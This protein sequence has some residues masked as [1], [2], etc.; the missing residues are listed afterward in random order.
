[1]SKFIVI[2]EEDD[3]CLTEIEANSPSEA[4]EIFA[5]DPDNNINDGDVILVAEKIHKF[6]VSTKAM[7]KPIHDKKNVKA[8]CPS[9]KPIA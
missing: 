7:V 9:K 8:N 5:D 2:M 4:A 6:A 3:E 1:M